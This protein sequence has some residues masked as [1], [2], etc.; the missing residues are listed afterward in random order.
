MS[1][2]LSKR[3]VVGFG[4]LV[5]LQATLHAQTVP[6]VGDAFILPGGATNYG[7]LIN[8]NVGGASGFQGLFLFDLTKLPPGTTPA[9]V[10]DASLRLFVNKIGSPGS[11][12]VNVAISSWSELTV[13][14]SPGPGVGHSVAGPIGIP[15]AGSYISIP[16]TAQVQSWLNGEPNNGLVITASPSSASIIFDS[17]ESTAT[18]HPAVLEVDLFGQPGS[19]GAPGIVGAAGPTGPTGP[20]GAT[21]PQG[22]IGA[23][24]AQGPTGPTGAVGPTG[25]TGQTGTQG[26]PGAAGPTGPTGAV[27]PTGAI[28][29]A[30][31]SGPAGGAGPT[32]PV[33]V[34]GPA[35]ATG[36]QGAPGVAGP[37]GP[38][39]LINNNFSYFL[40]PGAATITI[41]DT[42]THHNLQVDNDT[43]QPNV[44]LPHSTV[45]GAGT[46]L[47]IGGH[48]WSAQANTL[49]VG[50]Q[51]GDT[52]L[53]PA[54]GHI[55]P[56]GVVS[57]GTFW[58]INYSCEVL[59]DGNGH[60]YFLSNN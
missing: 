57:P 54:E 51:A 35:G 53:V 33:G 26:P 49:A 8:V 3:F 43:F 16:L 50:P 34:A 5:L 18:S 2:V 42:E 44:L 45:I 25:A 55:A 20:F 60:W 7:S 56:I 36:T 31:P 17:K 23:P 46:V 48:D 10:S 29:V 47:S 38:Q 52:L 37:R 13:N 15:G 30:G 41:S 11:I 12:N 1:G 21:G 9:N 58:T 39:G 59:S 22:A 6:L 32:G 40:F 4:A 27:G 14:G 19:V 28:G 24:G